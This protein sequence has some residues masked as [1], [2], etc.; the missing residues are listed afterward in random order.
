M[1]NIWIQRL[2]PVWN[3][4][5]KCGCMIRKVTSSRLWSIRRSLISLSGVMGDRAVTVL[6]EIYLRDFVMFSLFSI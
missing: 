2:L 4:R 3:V 5:F 6:H 1:Q